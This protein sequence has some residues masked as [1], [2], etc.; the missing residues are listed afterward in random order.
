MEMNIKRT[1][2]EIPFRIKTQAIVLPQLILLGKDSAGSICPL[3]AKAPF[4][5]SVSQAEATV[6]AHQEKS[7]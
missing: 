1:C 5:T 7:T 4:K 3:L 6:H 2:I